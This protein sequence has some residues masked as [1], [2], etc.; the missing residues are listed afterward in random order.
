MIWQDWAI[1]AITISFI[2]SSLNALRNPQTKYPRL[3]SI[4]VAAGLYLMAFVF[5]SMALWLA[6]T[7]ALCQ[8]TVW[9][10]IAVKRPI[11]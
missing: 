8:A 11:L 5:Y 10:F 6:G 3:T 4:W 2:L 9:V 7:V 1:S